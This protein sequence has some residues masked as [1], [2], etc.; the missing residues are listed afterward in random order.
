MN[1]KELIRLLLIASCTIFLIFT[2]ISL[3]TTDI[4]ACVDVEM[5]EK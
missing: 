2:G 3:Q 1:F 4:E 5:T